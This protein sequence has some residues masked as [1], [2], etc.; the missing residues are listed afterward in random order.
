MN[1]RYIEAASALA[2]LTNPGAPGFRAVSSKRACAFDHRILLIICVCVCVHSRVCECQ[3][4][5]VPSP[6]RVCISPDIKI[7]WSPNFGS[8]IL[9]CT[10]VVR[11]KLMLLY[12]LPCTQRFR[13]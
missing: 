13:V 6:Y 5:T 4:S 11:Y 8:Q 10:P 3:F 9:D 7:Y 2:R 1:K 12:F